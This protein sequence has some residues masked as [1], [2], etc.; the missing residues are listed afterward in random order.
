M[1]Q[2]STPVYRNGQYV[3]QRATRSNPRSGIEAGRVYTPQEVARSV[4]REA[5][6]RGNANEPTRSPNG[7]RGVRSN[8]GAEL[9]RLGHSLADYDAMRAEE[10]RDFAAG[11]AT[12]DRTNAFK[13]YLRT[14]R[15]STAL[16]ESRDM[17][18]GT[19]SGGGYLIPPGRY[20]AEL[21]LSLQ[22]HS[23]LTAKS[24]KWETPTGSTAYL[25]LAMSDTSNSA[26]AL[27]ENTQNSQSDLSLSRASFGECPTYIGGD[28]LRVS[29][30]LLQDAT[31]DVGG[32]VAQAFAQ[33][34][35]AAVDAANMATLLANGNI[36]TVTSAANTGIALAD[37]EA[38]L[39]TLDAV[40]RGSDWPRGSLVRI[41]RS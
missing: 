24:R 29:N 13:A 10:Q 37:L 28:L 16:V 2:R 36:P 26:L 12:D 7:L 6:A 39:Y 27:G 35:G 34:V 8:V 33:R 30:L 22:Y 3:G 18:Y 5:I 9:A 19:N 21:L 32:I 11:R 15:A 31:Y 20:N 25:P 17:G 23:A 41:P 14:G 1:A 38:A 4:A 40:Y